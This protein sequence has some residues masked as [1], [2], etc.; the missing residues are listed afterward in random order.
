MNVVYPQHFIDYLKR[1]QRTL[2]SVRRAQH[3]A[4]ELVNSA[5][6]E[7]ETL[8]AMLDLMLT[9]LC[10]NKVRYHLNRGLPKEKT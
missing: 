8:C 1:K 3:A 10:L 7:E 9:D 5:G 6:N 4:L 2:S